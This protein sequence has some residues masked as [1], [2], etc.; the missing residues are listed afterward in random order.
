MTFIVDAYADPPKPAPVTNTLRRKERIDFS[1]AKAT[2][3]PPRK[4]MRKKITP[5]TP[6]NV[7]SGTTRRKPTLIRNLNG[8]G[9]PKGMYKKCVAMQYAKQF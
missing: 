7:P 5:Q 6:S 9:A 2:E 8:A 1:V 3:N 4:T